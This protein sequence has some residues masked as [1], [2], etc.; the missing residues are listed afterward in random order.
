MIY[1]LNISNPDFNYCF[2]PR[3]LP[4]P[5]RTLPVLYVLFFRPASA[6]HVETKFG[7]L[8]IMITSYLSSAVLLFSSSSYQTQLIAVTTGTRKLFSSRSP[9]IDTNDVTS[10]PS[11]PLNTISSFNQ[12]TINPAAQSNSHAHCI[13]RSAAGRNH[14]TYGNNLSAVHEI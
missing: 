11:S 12:P 14:R 5:L 4:R 7:L 8:L 6:P 10:S 13:R 2:R 1:V 9:R 3:T